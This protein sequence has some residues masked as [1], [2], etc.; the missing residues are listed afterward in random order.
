MDDSEE[1]AAER[2]KK[3]AKERK[4]AEAKSV[5]KLVRELFQMGLKTKFDEA[6]KIDRF[7]LQLLW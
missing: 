6:D 7:F 4:K 5:P 2:E 3:L 1:A